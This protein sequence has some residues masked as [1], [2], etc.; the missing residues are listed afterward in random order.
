MHPETFPRTLYPDVNSGSVL[1]VGRLS[2][3]YLR[4]AV[5]SLSSLCH[6][7]GIPPVGQARACSTVRFLPQTHV[8]GRLI[9]ATHIV[10]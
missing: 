4:F 6:S 8:F 3:Q 2:M 9:D 10:E 7:V 1:A 5:R